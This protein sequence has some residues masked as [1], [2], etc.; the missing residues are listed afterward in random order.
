[1]NAFREA[2]SAEQAASVAAE[3]ATNPPDDSTGRFL[4]RS[5]RGALVIC[6]PL[7]VPV[8]GGRHPEDG[9]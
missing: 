9:R 1:M 6:R 2:R 4:G 3:L 7:P 5:G 8:R